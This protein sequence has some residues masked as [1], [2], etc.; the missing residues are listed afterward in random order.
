MAKTLYLFINGILTR[1]SDP[2]GWTDRAVTY[3]QA[4]CECGSAEKFEYFSGAMT[5]RLFQSGRVDIAADIVRNYI[6]DHRIV[7]VG[8]SNGC[9]II[10]R[11][12]ERYGFIIKEAHLFAAAAEKDFNRN[13]LNEALT[14]NRLGLVHVYTS[15]EDDVLKYGGGL[16][17]GLFGW[18]GMGYGTLGYSGP[19]NVRDKTRVFV[20]QNDRMNHGDWFAGENFLWSMQSVTQGNS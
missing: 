17:C 19:T 13:G 3:I 10:C 2:K 8:H 7:L 5:R 1:P 16:T 15:R 9:D 11:L 4:R 20:H 14:D 18:C 6:G 12:I